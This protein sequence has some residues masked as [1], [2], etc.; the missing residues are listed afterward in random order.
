MGQLASMLKQ[1]ESAGDPKTA[2]KILAAFSAGSFFAASSLLYSLGVERGD[3]AG[4]RN[5]TLKNNLLTDSDPDAVR[6]AC[7]SEKLRKE[8]RELLEENRQKGGG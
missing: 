6:F 7:V 5:I 2:E 8:A 4:I 3:N 1:V